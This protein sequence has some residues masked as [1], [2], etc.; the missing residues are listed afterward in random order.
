MA[1]KL[2][3]RGHARSGDACQIGGYCGSGGKFA[4]ALAAFAAGYADET[5][6]DYRAFRAAVES[7]RIKTARNGGRTR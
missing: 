7:G 1:G 2:L 4:R 3:A 5:E 6:A